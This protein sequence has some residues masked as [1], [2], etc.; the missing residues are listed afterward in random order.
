MRHEHRQPSEQAKTEHTSRVARSHRLAAAHVIPSHAECAVSRRQPAF[1]PTGVPVMSAPSLH[2]WSGQARRPLSSAQAAR[3]QRC[4]LGPANPR[5]VDRPV[6]PQ[7]ADTLQASPSGLTDVG[8]GP[9][10]TI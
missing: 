8:P 9:K 1:L 5:P 4:T 10:G 6:A 7:L 2:G 3:A